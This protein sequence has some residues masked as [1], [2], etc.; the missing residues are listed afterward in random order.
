MPPPTDRHMRNDMALLD[1]ATGTA[2]DAEFLNQMIPH[3]AGL[4]VFTLRALRDLARNVVKVQVAGIGEKQE[5]KTAPRLADEPYSNQQAC[6]S[7]P[8]AS[9][10]A[11]RGNLKFR[12][13]GL[14]VRPGRYGSASRRLISCAGNGTSSWSRFSAAAGR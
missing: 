10:P 13:D 3:H 8:W 6:P 1:R 12:T 9:V 7:E 5:L 2:V 11:G 4:L 14:P